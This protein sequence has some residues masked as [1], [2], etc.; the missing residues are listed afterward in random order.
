MVID[1]RVRYAA[2]MLLVLS[3]LIVAGCTQEER[4]TLTIGVIVPETGIFSTAGKAMKNSAVLAEEHIKKYGLSDY[5]VRVIFADGGSTP[6]QAKSAFMELAKQ[7]DIIIGAYSSDQAVVCAEAARETGKIYIVSV[8]STGQIEKMV[9]EGNRYVFRN[10]YNTTYWG[11]LAGEFLRVSG[12]ERY[13][14]VGYDPLKT[15]NQGMLKAFE[16]STT[17]E[18]IGEVYYLSTKVSPDDYAVKAEQV[19]KATTKRDVVILGDPGGT[20]IQFVKAYRKAGGQGLIYSVGGVLAL[21]T[22]LKKIDVDYIAFQCA[23]LESTEKSD[24]TKAYFSDYREKFG[25]EANNFAGL[26]TYDAVLIAAQ[27]WKG[28]TE[29][30]INALE[31]GEFR[32]AAGVYKFG[33]NHQAAWGSEKLRGI[34]AEYVDGRIEVVYPEE[35][36]TSDVVWP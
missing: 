17:A 8:A 24:L 3:G 2:L 13:Y 15:F 20:A 4:K 33:Q 34:I 26:L 10:S 27:A 30:T 23:G 32:G 21:P 14:F 9:K 19:A 18:K 12:A 7:A 1:M 31:N 36:R 35:Y 6:E 5:D 28:D 11:Y 16:G 29:K 22:I 25:E